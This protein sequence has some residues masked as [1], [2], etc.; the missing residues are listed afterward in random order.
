MKLFFTIHEKTRE[1]FIFE[2]S[3]CE[4][5]KSGLDRLAGERRDAEIVPIILA[6]DDPH[7]G[8]APNLGLRRAITDSISSTDLRFY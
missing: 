3:N 5:V 7:S 2:M 4:N 1:S 8:H 6:P